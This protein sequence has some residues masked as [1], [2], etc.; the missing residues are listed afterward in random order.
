MR[1]QRVC[2]IIRNPA[3]R[4]LFFVLLSGLGWC[5][6]LVIKQVNVI[7]AIGG[8]AKPDYSVVISGDRI[9]F[10]GPAKSA[11][12]PANAQIVDGTG[13]FLIPGLWDMH[14]HGA[15]DG[16]SA[17]TYPLF[18]ANGVVGV[19]EMFGPPD[20]REWRARQVG[21]G[22]PSP[23]VFLASPI[24]DGPN[25]Q[26]PASIVVA[27]EAQGRA[28]VADQQRR[29]AD[30]LKVYSRLPREAYFAIADEAH[31]RGIDFAG[32][33][34]SSVTAAEASDA[35]QRSIEH[36]RGIILGCSSEE[37]SILPELRGL[38]AI[39]QDPAASSS[40][41]MAVGP[42]ELVLEARSRT[43]YDEATARSLFAKFAKNKTWQC[44][45]LTVLRAQ[46]DNSQ[47]LSDPR[48]KYLDKSAR[49]YWERGFYGALPPQVRPALVES[50]KADFEEYTKIVGGM[51]RA[52]V[53]ILA[54]TD[55]LN[56]ECFPGFGLH[57]ELALLVDAGLSPLAA[58]QSATLN[59]AEFVGQADFRGTVAPGKIADLVLLD[60]DPLTD[61]HNTRSIRAVVFN[62]KLYSRGALDAM[63]AEAESEVSRPADQGK[64]N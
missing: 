39:L 26:W 49:E 23:Y 14:V 53:R 47:R 19:R 33:V 51:H 34:P 25:P 6:S 57:E 61:I 59:A 32:H 36:L 43:T 16:R 58:L 40:Q 11:K 48:V 18:L 4:S 62:G 7:D 21:R 30:F 3:S 44:P 24:I 42:R 38:Q 45:T 50:A 28:A 46:L 8:D 13:K 55:A 52:G 41:K 56:P 54:G 17:W 63:M 60:K 10:V 15:A 1:S 9:T 2:Q 64:K 29:G 37:K 35:G 27:D 31:R 5:Q 20:A 12:I 22:K